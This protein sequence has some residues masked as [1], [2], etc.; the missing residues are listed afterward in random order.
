MKNIKANLKYFVLLCSIWLIVIVSSCRIKECVFLVTS[1]IHYD[2]TIEKTAILDSVIGLMNVVKKLKIPGESGRMKTPFGVVIPGDLTESG[3]PAQWKQFTDSW[4]VNGEKKIKYQVF[5]S[6]GNHD[7]NIDD[8]VRTGVTKRNKFRREIKAISENGLHYSWDRNGIHF[9][10]LGS[11]PGNAW[12]STCGWCH[13]FK[14]SFKDPQES[15]A[16][17]E[18]DL[19]ENVKGTHKP[20]VLFFHYGWDDFS[21]LWWTGGEQ[22]AFYDIIKAENVV[23]IFHGHDHGVA[24]YKWNGINIWSDGSPQNGNKTGNFLLVHITGTNANVYSMSNKNVV[25]IK[26]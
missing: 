9:I 11:Y 15:L 2:G 25:Q 4:G 21:K 13:Y 20:I 16:F 1:D 8:V 5:E 17:L 3:L 18:K 14:Q 7:G 26:Q 22:S 23:A 19:K 12:D 6:F 10:M 24:S